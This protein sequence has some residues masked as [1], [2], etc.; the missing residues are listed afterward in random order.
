MLAKVLNFIDSSSVWIG[1]IFAWMCL[2]MIGT[3]IFEVTARYIFNSPT[4]WAHESTTMLYGTFCMV[5]SIWTLREKGHVRTEVVYQMLPEKVQVLLDILTGLIILTM[6]GIFF[7]ASYEYALESWKAKEISSK[8]TWG[9]IVY[10]F[11][12]VIPVVAVLMFIQQLSHTIRD[13]AT[14]IGRP[15]EHADM[16]I[17]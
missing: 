12:T 10:P 4:E 7:Y 14:L 16:S 15:I 3:L 11:K 6:L 9:V 2:I 13:F 1:K 5:G 17:D 8:S